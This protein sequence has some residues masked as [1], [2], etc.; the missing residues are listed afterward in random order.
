MTSIP[1]K[2]LILEM[3]MSGERY[4]L[5]LVKAS[6][7]RLKRGTIY[8]TLGRMEDEGLVLSRLAADLIPRRLYKV[9]ERGRAVFSAW[10]MS[11]AHQ[12]QEVG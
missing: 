4:G 6:K 10:E 1:K 5:D 8:I 3:L 12:T 9:T 2:Y 11:A 7:G